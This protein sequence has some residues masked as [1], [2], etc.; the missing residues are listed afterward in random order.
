MN[1][2]NQY[3]SPK[4]ET[5]ANPLDGIDLKLEQSKSLDESHSECF[6]RFQTPRSKFATTGLWRKKRDIASVKI[7]HAR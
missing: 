5:S 4:P 6:Q 7:N 1:P 3:L 2:S